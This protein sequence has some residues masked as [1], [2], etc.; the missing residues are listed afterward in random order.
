MKGAMDKKSFVRSCSELEEEE[1][2]DHATPDCY[3]DAA[4]GKPLFILR[5]GE[6]VEELHG[7]HRV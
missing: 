3:E 2:Y 6:Q 4:G 1:D 7:P 5:E